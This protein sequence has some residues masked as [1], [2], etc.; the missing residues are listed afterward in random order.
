MTRKELEQLFDEFQAEWNNKSAEAEDPTNKDQ[1]MDLAFLWC[2]KL[3]IP[4]ETIRHGYAYQ[5][6]AA[7]APITYQYFDLIPNTDTFVPLK[8]DIAVFGI[9][10]GI[11]VGHIAVTTGSSDINNLITFDE[12]WDTLHYYHVDP[13]TGEHLPYCRTVVHANYYGMKN[14]GF[15]RLKTQEQ[16]APV[17]VVIPIATTQ[18][19]EIPV[20]ATTSG[21]STVVKVGTDTPQVIQVS[22]DLK[23]S[24]EQA[25]PSFVLRIFSILGKLWTYI[26][27]RR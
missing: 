19:T 17:V 14:T 22:Q 25:K 5:V 9:T 26:F 3:G 2:D 6:W 13:Q 18:S 4:R 21:G 24:V 15:L 23:E 11:P 7:P 27:G 16:P 20:T 12:N 1:C 10:N 8:G